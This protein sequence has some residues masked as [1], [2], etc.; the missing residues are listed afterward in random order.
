MPPVTAETQP[1]AL[2]AA[3]EVA[4]WLEGQAADPWQSTVRNMAVHISGHQ[5][6]AVSTQSKKLN[7]NIPRSERL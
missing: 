1:F 6:A 5:Y 7:M 4:G 2:Q 3:S